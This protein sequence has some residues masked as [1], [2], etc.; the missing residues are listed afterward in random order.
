MQHAHDTFDTIAANTAVLCRAIHCDCIIPAAAVLLARSRDSRLPFLGQQAVHPPFPR[1]SYYV[2]G[3][4]VRTLYH[5][6]RNSTHV[7]YGLMTYL[8]QV[9]S[10]G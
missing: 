9:N 6:F 7:F 2:P 5:R 4:A 8:Y 10:S 3:T 1:L